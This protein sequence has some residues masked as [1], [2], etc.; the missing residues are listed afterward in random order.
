[1]AQEKNFISLFTCYVLS[2]FICPFVVVQVCSEYNQ[3]VTI[4]FQNCWLAFFHIPVESTLT[5]H[6]CHAAAFAMHPTCPT[7]V[8][9]E[10]NENAAP[11]TLHTAIPKLKPV[12]LLTMQLHL[13]V[14]LFLR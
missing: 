11:L 8:S 3:Y 9:L 6:L 12:L 2:F 13:G 5:D 10:V 1:M 14:S 4:L 7:K